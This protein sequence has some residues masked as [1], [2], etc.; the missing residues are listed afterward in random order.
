MRIGLADRNRAID[1][2]QRSRWMKPG[3]HVTDRQ[4][5]SAGRVCG[6]AAVF[7]LSRTRRGSANLLACLDL[8]RTSVVRT[9][10]QTTFV[11]LADL[12][13]P[14]LVSR[15]LI[16]Y[17]HRRLQRKLVMPSPIRPRRLIC[18]CLARDRDER[19]DRRVSSAG[20]KGESLSPSDFLS[21]YRDVLDRRRMVVA[22]AQADG[23][24]S[25]SNRLRP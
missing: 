13:L 23:Q 6:G 18:V 21:R 19:L 1:R 2:R 17:R 7:L 22:D 16:Y 24:L 10:A 4:F 3:V 5:P 8:I 20:A 11:T 25:G 15:V 12:V 9:F 14:P